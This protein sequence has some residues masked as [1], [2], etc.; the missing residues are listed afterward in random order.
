MISLPFFAYSGNNDNLSSYSVNLKTSKT[1]GFDNWFS[2][3]GY[4]SLGVKHSLNGSR[5]F[6]MVLNSEYLWQYGKM[7][8][9]PYLELVKINNFTGEKDRNAL[10]STTAMMLRYNNWNMSGSFINRNIKNKIKNYSI[11]DYQAQISV[12]YKFK[13]GFAIDLT[14][15]NIKESSLNSVSSKA[16]LI[17]ANLSYLYK[18]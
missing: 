16:S 18:F 3:L 17:G 11:K 12:G 6:G 15:A 8:I 10:Y 13:N 1:L 4:R 9:V 2:N 7:S 14:R 5:E